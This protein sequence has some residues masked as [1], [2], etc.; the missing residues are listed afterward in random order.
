MM[1]VASGMRCMLDKGS[2]D[3]FL[4]CQTCAAKPAYRGA[5]NAVQEGIYQKIAATLDSTDNPS[6][7]RS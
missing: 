5:K 3:S 4:R 7:R 2:Q 1:I 6:T